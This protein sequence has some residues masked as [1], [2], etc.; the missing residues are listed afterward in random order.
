MDSDTKRLLRALILGLGLTILLSVLMG[1]AI[2]PLIGG[3]LQGFWFTFVLQ[4]LGNYFYNDYRIR[5]R[6]REEEINLN[7]RLDILSRNLINFD[8]PCGEYLFNEAIYPGKD[9]I[10]KCEKCNQTI[11][12]DVAMTPV[13]ITQ[14]LTTNP[15]EKI[16]NSSLTE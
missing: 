1:Y 11:R 5:T 16:Q 2:A 9:N 4:V 7:E 12:V 3:W 6:T 10:F 8:C 13:V 14:P 15:L